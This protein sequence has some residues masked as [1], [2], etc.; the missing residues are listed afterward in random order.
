[1]QR[2]RL[3]KGR[4][5]GVN[6]DSCNRYCAVESRAR[7]ALHVDLCIQPAFNFPNPTSYPSPIN[8]ANNGHHHLCVAVLT[9]SNWGGGGLPVST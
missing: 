8:A 5:G 7:G 1:M 6:A 4:H 2:E 9:W 3:R